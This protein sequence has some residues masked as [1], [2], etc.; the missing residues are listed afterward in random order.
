[1]LSIQYVYERI[2]SIPKYRLSLKAGAKIIPFFYSPNIPQSFFEKYFSLHHYYQKTPTI[3]K[4]T[5]K[6]MPFLK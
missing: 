2:S 3:I 5:A 4:G 1:V 6:I